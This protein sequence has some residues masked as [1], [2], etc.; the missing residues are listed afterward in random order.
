MWGLGQKHRTL[1]LLRWALKLLSYALVPSSQYHPGV[2][3]YFLMT[4]H[5][6]VALHARCYQPASLSI[7][8]GPLISFR[9]ENKGKVNNSCKVVKECAYVQLVRLVWS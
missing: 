8:P 2:L 1:K 4:P 6:A 5:L 7:L 9:K 3:E